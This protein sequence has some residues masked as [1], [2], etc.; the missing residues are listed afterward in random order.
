MHESSLVASLLRQVNELTA[1][2]RALAVTEIRIEIGLLAGVEP[3]L[4]REAFDRLRIGTIAAGAS[5]AI[6][7]IGLTCRCRSCQLSYAA[8]EVRFVC[9]ACGDRHVDVIGGDAVVLVSCALQQSEEA[10]VL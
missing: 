10:A 8:P 7:T 6:D 5:L 2:H 9:P 1:E 4:L 3:V